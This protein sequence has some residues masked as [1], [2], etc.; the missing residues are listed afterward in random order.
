M[1][2]GSWLIG[3]GRWFA[4]VIGLKKAHL[5]STVCRVGWAMYVGVV[6]LCYIIFCLG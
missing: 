6:I 5:L 4:E 2:L 3:I 1:E